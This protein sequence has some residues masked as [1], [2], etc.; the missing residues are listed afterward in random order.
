[1]G[2]H[3]AGLAKSG[4]HV[5]FS[6]SYARRRVGHGRVADTLEEE[7]RFDFVGRASLDPQRRVRALIA[8]ERR[9]VTLHEDAAEGRGHVQLFVVAEE[10]VVKGLQSV[11]E[12]VTR[13]VAERRQYTGR[14]RVVVEKVLGVLDQVLAI[15]QDGGSPD[16]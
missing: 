14:A 9:R 7:R 13:L 10:V 2:A 6:R 1:E 3:G 16:R 15:D 8:D 12:S 11:G 5:R 4:R